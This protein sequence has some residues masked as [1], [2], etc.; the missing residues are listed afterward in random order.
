MPWLTSSR[1]VL[2]ALHYE[3]SLILSNQDKHPTGLCNALQ[4]YGLQLL[5]HSALSSF[6]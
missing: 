5:T 6:L 2:S 4:A 3:S 1:E